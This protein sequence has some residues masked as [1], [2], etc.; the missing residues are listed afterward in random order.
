MRIAFV[1]HKFPPESVGGV[2][3][4]SWSLAR[5]LAQAGHEAHVFYPVAGTSISASR[6]DQD[7]IYRWRVPVPEARAREGPVRQF[8]HTFRDTAIEA[9]FHEFLAQ[10]QPDIVHFQ[11]VQGVSA[12]LISLASG[13]PLLVT[14]HDYW[15]F[16]AN[17]QLVRPDGQVCAGPKWGWNCVD[18]LTVR[19]DLRWLRALRPLVAWPLAGR[20]LYLR[21][22]LESV[23][24]ILT[25]SEFVRQQYVGQGFPAERIVTLE[26]GL[27]VE[28]LSDTSGNGMPVPLAR[29]HFGFLGTL[30]PHKGVHVLVEAFNRLPEG[31]ALTIYGSETVS[32]HYVAQLKVAATH[33]NIRFAGALDYANV[34]TA[35]RQLDCL[36][37]PSI[38]FETYGLV[39]QEA[40]G[41]GVPVVASCLGALAEKVRDGET[42]RLFNAGDS[43]D[44]ARILRELMDQ[45]EQLAALRANI[46]PA[47]TM[48][49]HAQQMLEIYQAA[50]NGKYS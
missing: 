12:H 13:F 14:L 18:C 27:D 6:A 35:L 16:C 37:V 32:P 23:P 1:V 4:Y 28:R 36:V 33:P 22:A 49:Q 11:H 8:W 26:L 5:V 30:A 40:Y 20:N 25:P 38:W 3:T 50:L 21:Q 2:E 42:G 24:L 41:V 19:A 39:V 10:V 43:T 34:G 48:Q 45:P 9:A 17:S 29:P 15:F 31:A 7:G 47:P 44:L 46:R